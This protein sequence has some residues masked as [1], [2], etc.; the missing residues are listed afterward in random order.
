MG[1]SN[2]AARSLASHCSILLIYD[3]E[4]RLRAA[5]SGLSTPLLTSDEGLAIAGNA[6]VSRKAAA[7]HFAEIFGSESVLALW[8]TEH[9]MEAR[10][11]NDYHAEC[12]LEHNGIPVHV[13]LETLK[14]QG[15][16]YG[17]AL[18]IVDRSYAL[19]D[20][21]AIVTRQQWHD[22]KNHLGGV[23]LYATFLKRKL[24]D[25]EDQTIVDKILNGIN[26]LIEQL[27]R[28]RRGE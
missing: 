6:P 2:S 15:K 7:P 14:Q 22:I 8:L 16:R 12:E 17:F 3:M 27:A 19:G 21:D 24:A 25:S 4:G 28:I 13:K 20:G 1:L 26:G 23:K 5:S 18:L 9:Y 10:A 11:A